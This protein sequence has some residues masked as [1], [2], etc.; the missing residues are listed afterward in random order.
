MLFMFIVLFDYIFNI[1]NDWKKIKEKKRYDDQK[2]RKIS[3]IG[4]QP[5]STTTARRTSITILVS[6]SWTG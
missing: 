4:I 2:M 6:T 3:G 5:S 1:S